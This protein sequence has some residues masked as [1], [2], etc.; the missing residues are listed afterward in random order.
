M[1]G[2]AGELSGRWNGA[3]NDRVTGAES[4]VDGMKNTAAMALSGSKLARRAMDLSLAGYEDWYIPSKDEL[5][6]LYRNFKP[7]AT[8]NWSGSGDN[9]SSVPVGAEYTRELP[10]QTTTA[11][12]I[13]DE[14]DALVPAWYWSSTQYAAHPDQR[15]EPEF[16]QWRPERR[17]QVLRRAR[18][19]RPQICHS[20]I[21]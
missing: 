7:S 17:P 13:E 21:Q 4:F 3:N 5:E 6:L 1:A 15:V 12:L 9:D 10:A 20:V 2:A 18:A 11:A 8:R 19:C 16:R 14:A